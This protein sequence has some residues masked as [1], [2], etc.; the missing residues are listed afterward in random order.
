MYLLFASFAAIT[1]GFWWGLA[2]WLVLAKPAKTGI[3]LPPDGQFSSYVG[4]QILSIAS[5]IVMVVAWI[6][7]FPLTAEIFATT[8]RS[9]LFSGHSHP[10]TV[11]FI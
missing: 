2:Q 11:L 6:S 10:H 3:E 5:V 9:R 8:N 4:F 1:L 7:C